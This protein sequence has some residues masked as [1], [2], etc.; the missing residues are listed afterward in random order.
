M[1]FAEFYAK[2][3]LVNNRIFAD[4]PRSNT[5]IIVVIPCY[6]DDFVFTT[7]RSLDNAKPP[8]CAVEVIVVV[9]SA[10]NSPQAAILHNRQ[11]YAELVN[12]NYSNFTLKPH[13]IEQVPRKIAGVGNA[14]KIGMDEAVW[15][16]ASIDKPN[17]IIVSLDADCL[18]DVEYFVS[19]ERKFLQNRKISCLCLQYQH[20]FDENLYSHDE[21]IACKKYETYLRYFRLAQK[22]A[23]IPNALH[24]IGS[25][26]AVTAL[27]YTQTGGMSRRQAG[28]DF[29]F[30]QKQAQMANVD[31]LQKIVV[32]PS[33]SVS[34]RVPFGTGQAVKKILDTQEC[35]VYNFK[36]FL[37][38]KE[39]F[40]NLQLLYNKNVNIPSEILEFVGHEKFN[41]IL[42]EVKDNSSNEMNFRKRIFAKFDVFFMIRFLNS[43]NE[44]E[45]FRPQEIE[46]AAEN[47]L[48]YYHK[49]HSIDVYTEIMKLDLEEI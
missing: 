5:G 49:E 43:Y 37:M 30:L 9:N 11:I 4:N 39:F 3:Y 20:N 34:T 13:L 16:F 6:D 10:E 7:L 29:Y 17:G 12:A 47:L 46:I 19:I 18:V 40:D 24:T 8:T 1:N 44:S 42:Q 45:I 31:T 27:A 32:F 41:N 21:I 35:K 2:R 23:G 38:L 28:E 33:P 36:L 48:N 25:C 22:V 26:F 14:R 15:R